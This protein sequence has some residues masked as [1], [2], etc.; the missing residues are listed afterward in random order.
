MSRRHR[1]F[2]MFTLWMLS[3]VLI[4]FLTPI[5]KEY[6]SISYYTFVENLKN[7]EISTVSYNADENFAIVRN[8]VDDKEYKLNIISKESISYWSK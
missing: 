1:L 4:F 6:P 5:P 7:K 3:M 2:Q 8:S